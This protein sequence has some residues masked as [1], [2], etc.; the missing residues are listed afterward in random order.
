MKKLTICALALITINAYAVEHFNP[1]EWTTGKDTAGEIEF[2]E[3]KMTP[4]SEGD[5]KI[6][7]YNITAAT[8]PYYGRSGSNVSMQGNHS[9]N[10]YNY[11]NQRTYYTIN[12]YLCVISMSCFNNTYSIAVDAGYHYQTRVNSLLNSIFKN[13]ANYT[14][15]AGTRISGA[16]N[17]LAYDNKPL[18]ISL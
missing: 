13:P 5:K 16:E 12:I 1:H 15:Q 18:N 7:S 9:V 6:F 10:L 14:L 4:I 17:A 3:E 2:I 11:S 8:Q